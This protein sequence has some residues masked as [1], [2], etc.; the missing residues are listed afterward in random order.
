MSRPDARALARLPAADRAAFLDALSELEAAHLLHDWP[1]WARPEQLPP[2]T[3]WET[4][5][6]LAGRGFG[7]TRTG[8]EW[9]RA[10]AESGRRRRFA[11]VGP[12][13]RDVR[14]TM[15]EGESGIIAVSPPWF[16]PLFVRSELR[17]VWPNGAVADLYSAERPDRLRGPAHDG[18]WAD[19]LAAWTHLE[20]TWDNLELTLRGGADPR[21]VVTTTPKPRPGLKRL[22]LDPTTHVTRGATA[23]NADNLARGYVA[24]MERRYAGTRLGRQEL[25]AE[26][27]EDAEGALWSLARLDALRVPAAPDLARVVVAVDP[28]VSTGPRAAETGIVVAGIAADGAGYVLAD[29][30]G[31]LRPEEWAGRAVAAFRHHRADRIVGETNNGGDLVEATLRAVDPKLPFRAVTASRG[32]RIR[33]EPVAALYEQGRVRHVGALAA[34]EDQMVGWRPAEGGPSPDRV[35]ALVWALT[36]LMLGDQPFFYVGR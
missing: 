30:S 5:L 14:K 4:W 26:L 10:E 24:R 35:D 29:L 28:A 12:T 22:I 8:A 33:A 7:K 32:K 36:E 9:V 11:L 6:V 2:P 19:E 31:R 17:L 23:A 20:E 3:P 18:A 13:L 25:E 34:L 21:R 27:L 15:V 16:R 1:F